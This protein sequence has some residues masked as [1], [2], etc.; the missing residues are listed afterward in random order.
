MLPPVF[1]INLPHCTERKDRMIKRLAYYNF[2]STFI[3]AIDKTSALVEWYMMGQE[4]LQ[5]ERPTTLPEAACL[6]S[7]LK[8][9]RTAV[10]TR[11]E[12][13][14]YL[15]LEDDALLRDDC[16]SKFDTWMDLGF[17]IINP[18]GQNYTSSPVPRNTYAPGLSWYLREVW[19][20]WT[21]TGYLISRNYAQHILQLLDKPFRYLPYPLIVSE[22]IARQANTAIY[23]DEPHI[24]EDGYDSTIQPPQVLASHQRFFEYKYDYHKFLQAEGITYE[25]F[26]KIRHPG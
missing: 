13:K 20:T 22:L 4:G 11:P 21:L 6:L 15:I 10:Q 3:A 24:L 1:V 19:G 5:R 17:D 23:C 18:S 12:A 9:I 8:A 7:H 16:I 25:Q 14:Y 26:Q 2:D